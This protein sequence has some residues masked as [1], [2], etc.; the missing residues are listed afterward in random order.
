MKAHTFVANIFKM[1]NLVNW[2]E[3]P[4]SDFGRAVNFYKSILDIEITETE[5]FEMQMGLFP[6]DGQNVSG[7]IVKG[8][9]YKPSADG[10][11]MYLNGGED[12]SGILGRVEKAGGTIIVPKTLINPETGFMAMFTDTEGNRMALHSIK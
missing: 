11:L 8:D 5:M 6:S 9:M 3:I 7:A 10:A 4:A 2:F 12:L 1:K